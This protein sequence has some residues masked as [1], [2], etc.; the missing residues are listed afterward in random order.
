MQH[1]RLAQLVER[2]PYKQDVTGSSP[3]SPIQ[4]LSSNGLV[5]FA[6]KLVSP[7]A[8]PDFTLNLDRYLA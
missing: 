4:K 5:V 7:L 3:V 6:N 1:G 2:L 8:F